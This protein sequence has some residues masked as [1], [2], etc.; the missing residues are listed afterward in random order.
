MNCHQ[1][2][3]RL[4]EIWVEDKKGETNSFSYEFKDTGLER[5][6]ALDKEF[7]IGDRVKIDRYSNGFYSYP[8]KHDESRA[9]NATSNV[10]TK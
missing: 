9:I 6:V 4:S 10:I 7:D 5:M 1:K 2:K 8:V 3:G